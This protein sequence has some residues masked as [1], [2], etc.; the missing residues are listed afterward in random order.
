M[1]RAGALPRWRPR[2]LRASRPR[3][4]TADDVDEVLT[5]LYHDH[6]RPLVRLARLLLH[7]VTTAEVITQ[8]AFAGMHSHYRRLPD[9]AAHMAYL[10]QVVVREARRARRRLP[11]PLREDPR[12]RHLVAFALLRSLPDR[13]REALVL[14]YY[15]NLSAAEAA[16]AMGVT[17]GAVRRHTTRALS[18]A[19]ET[20]TTRAP[21][22]RERAVER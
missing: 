12:P 15:A 5:S 16:A 17:Q 3:P 20:M 22:R 7:D 21:T 8:A 14:R 9:H 1:T 6:Y 10:R 18:A 19:R 2:P 11:R 13:Q 4:A